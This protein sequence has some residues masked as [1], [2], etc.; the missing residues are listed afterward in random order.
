MKRFALVTGSTLLLA[1]AACTTQTSTTAPG[2]VG[3]SSCCKENKAATCDAA[4]KAAC[5]KAEVKTDA[6]APAPGAVSG[7]KKTGCGSSCPM[8][9]MSG[10]SNG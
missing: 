9:G 1:L 8:S 2:A 6:A 5:T 10:K 3:S 7:A 4:A